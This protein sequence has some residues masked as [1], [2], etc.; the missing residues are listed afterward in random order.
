MK[1]IDQVITEL[2]NAGNYNV[3][4]WEKGDHK[5][6]YFQGIGYNTKKMSTKVWLDCNNDFSFHVR[7][8]CD[9]QTYSW[10]S[11]Q[12]QLIEDQYKEAIMEIVN[13]IEE[14]A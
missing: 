6:I 14:V 3:S 7:I 1:N 5:R 4:L 8:D 11:S 9:S 12:K 10:I 13:S 2:E